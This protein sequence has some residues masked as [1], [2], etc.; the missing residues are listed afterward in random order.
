ML[1]PDD[2]LSTLAQTVSNIG[3]AVR[4]TGN[5]VFEHFKTLNPVYRTF[6]MEFIN[7]DNY[8]NCMPGIKTALHTLVVS[9]QDWTIIQRK[10]NSLTLYNNKNNKVFYILFSVNSNFSFETRTVKS[11]PINILTD[12]EML[13]ICLQNIVQGT[14]ESALYLAYYSTIRDKSNITE[15]VK[16]LNTPLSNTVNFN[17]DLCPI[18]ADALGMIKKDWKVIY[19]DFLNFYHIIREEVH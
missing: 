19:D 2:I 9:H 12:N 8:I 3:T 4:F 1:F 17:L 5:G 10:S 14:N 11:I 7:T 15:I 18:Y 16:Y 13:A 6:T